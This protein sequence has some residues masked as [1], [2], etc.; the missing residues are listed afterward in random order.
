MAYRELKPRAMGHLPLHCPSLL[1]I[2]RMKR[3]RKMFF[4]LLPISKGVVDQS[5]LKITAS[6]ALPFGH[7]EP[8]TPKITVFFTNYRTAAFTAISWVCI[9]PKAATTNHVKHKMHTPLW[10]GEKFSIKTAT[11]SYQQGTFLFLSFLLI[12]LNPNIYSLGFRGKNLRK[13]ININM[14]GW[15]DR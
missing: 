9:S 3:S 10:N 11:H 13:P 5:F 1:H 6:E 4:L 2:L 15:I 14:D 8:E 7:P 12:F